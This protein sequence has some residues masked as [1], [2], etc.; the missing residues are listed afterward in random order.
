MN[1]ARFKK[2][3]PSGTGIALALAAGAAM[4][5]GAW[6]SVTTSHP[7][8][9]S[10]QT[11][12]KPNIVFILTDDMRY[13]DLTA[14][15]MPKTTSLLINRGMAF[16]NA[17]VSNPLCCPSRATIMRGQYAHNTGVWRTTNVFDPDPNVRDGGW[18]GYK[19]NGYEDNN[20]ATHL[21]AAGYRTGFFGK[22]LNGYNDTN[23]HIPKGWDRW[24]ATEEGYFD[25]DVNDQ[26]T[27]KHFGTDANDYQTDVLKRRAS[28][29]VGTSVTAG[30]PFFAYVAPKAPH[31]PAIPAPR[32]IHTFDGV[33]DPRLPS[34]D[35]EDVSDKPPWMR[36][37]SR[38]SS[39]DEANI[40]QRHA[41]RVESLQAVDDLV[42]AVVR[43]LRD[44]GVLSN[45]YIVF[46]SDNGWYHGEH[47][48]RQGKARPYEEAPHVPLVIRGPGVRADSTTAKLALNTDY[49]PTFTGLAGARTPNYVD[50]RSLLPIL[51]ERATAWRTAILLEGTVEIPSLLFR[52]GRNYGGVRTSTTKYVEYEGG[53]RELY[54][55]APGADP[56]EQN[57]IYYEAAS[58]VA[59][60]PDLKARLDALESCAGADASATSCKTVEGG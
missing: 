46:T 59:P 17:F 6:I 49:F 11:A 1:Q 2:A 26:G 53:F 21:H 5:L 12:S 60:R 10:A 31:D 27:I 56:Y 34:F 29:F 22:Y 48:I 37:L 42:A 20:V 13:D 3:E 9:S 39:A 23:T 8:S 52:E 35:E 57:N 54:D 36:S 51:T 28:A 55:L 45:T 7:E 25:Y 16:D 50:G 44:K 41:D 43:K 33:Q 38:L 40:R 30:K 47:R 58:N 14:T 18:E 19:N 4:A 15:Y 32:D 24:F